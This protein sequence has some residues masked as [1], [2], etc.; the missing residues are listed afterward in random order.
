MFTI[1]RVKIKKS[2]Y[3][4]AYDAAIELIRAQGKYHKVGNGCYGDVFAAKGSDIV[5]KIGDATNNDGYLAYVNVLSKQRTHNKFTPKIYGVRIYELNADEKY[6]VVAMERL[7]EI[8]HYHYKLVDWF[9][10][11]FMN[12][13]FFDIMLSRELGIRI[14]KQLKDL[15]LL[16]RKSYKSGCYIDWDL[17]EGNFMLRGD[18][19]VIIDPLA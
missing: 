18:Q 9:A 5:Y 11:M 8:K 14:P 2:E 13:K 6:F 4:C 10:S 3:D 16:M 12:D 19:I 17:H 1:E 15:Y 7:S